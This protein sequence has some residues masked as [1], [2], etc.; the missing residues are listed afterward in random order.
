MKKM[1]RRFWN[2]LKKL[3]GG[4]GSDKGKPVS[5]PSR[6]IQGNAVTYANSSL[7]TS[8]RRPSRDTTPC[9]YSSQKTVVSNQRRSTTYAD[10]PSRSQD[11]GFVDGLIIGSILSQPSRNETPI[12]RPTPAFESGGEVSTP[13]FR[14][15]GAVINSGFTTGGTDMTRDY[16]PISKPEPSYEKT[17]SYSAPEKTYESPT[18][19]KTESSSS[20]YSS[21]SDSSSSYSSSD[22]GSSSSSSGE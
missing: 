6:P 1:M 4:G 18:Y 11:D 17:P 16:T 21:S 3:Y 13:S 12:P 8:N 10:T 22:S 15:G 20:S 14:S 19:E 5:L 9:T 2:W 7:G